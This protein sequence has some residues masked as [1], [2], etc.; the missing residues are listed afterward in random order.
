MKVNY[1]GPDPMFR[2]RLRNTWRDLVD[3]KYKIDPSSKPW[4]RI[5]TAQRAVESLYLE[6]YQEPLLPSHS[7]G[8]GGKSPHGRS[9]A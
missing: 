7:A 6:L 1:P 2:Q 9:P 4:F 5:D 8:E 3:Q